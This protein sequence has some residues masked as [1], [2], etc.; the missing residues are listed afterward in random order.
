MTGDGAVVRE[1]RLAPISRHSV[2]G[3]RSR[4]LN[5]NGVAGM[6]GVLLDFEQRGERLLLPHHEQ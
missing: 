3:R 4:W 2:A 6:V 1:R 5:P